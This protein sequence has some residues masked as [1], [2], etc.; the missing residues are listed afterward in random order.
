MMERRRKGAFRMRE[1]R[2][3]FTGLF[4][5]LLLVEA[6]LLVI[7]LRERHLHENSLGDQFLLLQARE[8]IDTE[9]EHFIRLS[10][11]ALKAATTAD[12]EQAQAHETLLGDLT[13]INASAA[14]P[15]TLA[16]ADVS[17]RLQRLQSGDAVFPRK[18][19][20]SL[21]AALADA[22]A[23]LQSD[24]KA[25]HAARGLFPDADG[26]FTVRGE[27]DP[28]LMRALHLNEN[29]ERKRHSIRQG[30][31]DFLAALDVRIYA[32]VEENT[33]TIRRYSELL[34]YL[35]GI[36]L[37]ATA[38]T[39]L[40][41]YRNISEPL[42]SFRIHSRKINDDLARTL[43]QLEAVSAERDALRKASPTV[44]PAEEIDQTS[45]RT[46]LP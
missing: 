17:S 15:T 21:N 43:A 6:V 23:I 29:L 8:A 12:K 41:L 30:L 2:M 39:G 3:L 22:E 40:L 7:V 5:G 19:V 42:E 1:F 38:A 33:D 27:S 25:L 13:R 9:L 4:T 20:A 10:D 45:Q 32:S 11:L 34:S 37:V 28:S 24:R 26:S 36:L 31:S 18:D 35:L 14:K 16:A 46:L 44:A